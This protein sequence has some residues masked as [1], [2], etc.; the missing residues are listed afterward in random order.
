MTEQEE[1]RA[2]L[3]RLQAENAALKAAGRPKHGLKVTDK[4]GLSLYGLGRFP[5][6]LY[7]SQWLALIAMAGVIAEFIKANDSKLTTKE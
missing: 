4:G 3:L 1:M 7:K 2:E 5:V 6:T